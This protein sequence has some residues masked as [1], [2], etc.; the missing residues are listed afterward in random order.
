MLISKPIHY[1][2]YI[3]ICVYTYISIFILTGCPNK[4]GNKD[5][6]TKSYYRVLPN[7]CD[8]N[9][10][11]SALNKFYVNGKKLFCCMMS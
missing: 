8:L 2:K 11:T 7:F 1:H 5:T 9:K 4:H 10:V 3:Y 6:N